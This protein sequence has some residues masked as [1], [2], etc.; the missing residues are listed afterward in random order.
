MVQAAIDKRNLPDLARLRALFPQYK[1]NSLLYVLRRHDFDAAAAQ[2][3]L[4]TSSN[5]RFWREFH[6]CGQGLVGIGD[7]KPV[8]V[9]QRKVAAPAPPPPPEPEPLAAEPEQPIEDALSAEVIDALFEAALAELGA[10]KEVEPPPEPEPADAD[11]EVEEEP[12][13]FGVAGSGGLG[14]ALETYRCALKL[15]AEG[16]YSDSVPL[17]ERCV[18]VFEQELPPDS[19]HTVQAVERLMAA[20]KA[21]SSRAGDSA[22]AAAGR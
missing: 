14:D 12:A 7:V 16:R 15:S 5:T 3:T 11:D 10:T 8:R 1:T 19:T 2:R 20:Y 17:L 21:D 6:S 13:T 9:R 4:L 18:E 22:A